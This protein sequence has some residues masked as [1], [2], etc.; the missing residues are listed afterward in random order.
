MRA[1]RH[2]LGLVRE[3]GFEP[4][5]CGPPNASRA[6]AS[7]YSAI[8][9]QLETGRDR[10]RPTTVPLFFDSMFGGLA[11]TFSQRHKKSLIAIGSSPLVVRGQGVAS[12]LAPN[13]FET[14]VAFSSEL[15]ASISGNEK[16]PNQRLH[17]NPGPVC[18]IPN[19]SNYL[20]V[21]RP[22]HLCQTRNLRF[23]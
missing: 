16:G 21:R 17:A 9:A 23:K 19:I 8:P 3:A 15:A 11:R 20:K 4:A 10:R 18:P 12:T 1:L 14:Y 5:W 7:T 22:A 13:L 6:F 2:N